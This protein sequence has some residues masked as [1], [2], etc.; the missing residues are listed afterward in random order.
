M[1]IKKLNN[2]STFIFDVDGV[3]TNGNVQVSE[4]GHMLRTFNIKDGFAMQLAIKLGYRICI[5]T[6]GSSQGVVKR[7]NGLGIKDVFSKVHEKVPVYR[8]YLSDNNIQADEVAYM[9]DDLPDYTLLLETGLKCCPLDA[10][11]DIVNIC[12]FVSSKR[13]GEGCV[14]ELIEKVLRAQDKWDVEKIGIW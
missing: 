9:G 4:E 1:F 10:S 6:G 11:P 13:G 12:E 8:K 5:I 7:L 3:M 14:R 2:I